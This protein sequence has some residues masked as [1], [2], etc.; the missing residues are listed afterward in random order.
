MSLDTVKQDLPASIIAIGAG[1]RMRTYAHYL[2]QHPEEGKIVAVVEPNDYR[3]DAL[4]EAFGVPASHRFASYED[5]FREPVSGDAVFICTPD[6]DHFRCCLLAVQNGYNVLLEKPI[7]Q[8]YEECLI[9]D[10]AVRKAGVIVNVC[11]VMH[12]YPCYIK[13]KG[14][15]QDGGLGKVVS[16]N[17]TEWV[18]LNR[19]T[20][21]YVRGIF[22]R[23]EDSNPMFLA[24][25]CHDVDFLLWLLGDVSI[26]KVSSFG[27]LRWFKKENA[28]QGSAQRCIDCR[29]EG[30]CPF[31]AVNLYWRK[32]EWISNI[33][34]LS[35]ETL[36]DSIQRELRTGDIGRCVYHCNNDVVDHQ[37]V[38]IDTEDGITIT[39]LMECFTRKDSRKTY[40]YMT[41]GEI[42][43]N[44]K[45]IKV[46]RFL[47]NQQKT[48]NFLHTLKQPFHAGADLKI[49]EE[50]L[51]AI[52]HKKNHLS[53]LLHNSIL[54][55]LVCYAAEESRVEGKVVNI[56]SLVQRSQGK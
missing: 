17:H 21:S 53:S 27:S 2:Q 34:I 43:C 52:R 12:Y 42:E 25:C 37:S 20:H 9:L 28:P 8:S 49:V 40:I 15:V 54:S 14:L 29:V 32:R 23:K 26:K 3:R 33:D 1:N 30:N 36:E 22:G 55:H 35:G 13:L 11:H 31:S 44:E 39:M 4:S 24:K 38:A 51:Y 56:S 50:F 7:A 48:Y 6:K 10:D 41:E 18:G 45:T 5:F 16:V 46:T 19:T 47:D